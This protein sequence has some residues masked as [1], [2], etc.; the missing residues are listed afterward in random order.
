MWLRLEPKG[1]KVPILFDD[2]KGHRT[3]LSKA[4]AAELV[5]AGIPEVR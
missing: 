3:I 4:R 2:R 5:A 1:P